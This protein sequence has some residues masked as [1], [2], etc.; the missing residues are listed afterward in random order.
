MCKSKTKS[1]KKLGFSIENLEKHLVV[2]QKKVK[3]LRDNITR[4][5]HIG[6][7]KIRNS[8][9]QAISIQVK[10]SRFVILD[11]SGC[12]EKV[13]HEINRSSFEQKLENSNKMYKKS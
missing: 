6:L 13:Q 12:E 5:E 1:N 7:K 11:N 8:D 3:Q 10:G 4:E 2:H 9:K